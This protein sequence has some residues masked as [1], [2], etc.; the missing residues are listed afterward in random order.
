M[1]AAELA[2]WPDFGGCFALCLVR[3][4]AVGECFH[5]T[6]AVTGLTPVR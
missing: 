6:Q 3:G 4:C 2:I 5:Y 1:G